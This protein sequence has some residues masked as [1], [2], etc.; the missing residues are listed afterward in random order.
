MCSCL[1]HYLSFKTGR[2]HVFSQVQMNLRMKTEK[3]NIFNFLC[4]GCAI[5]SAKRRTWTKLPFIW[6]KKNALVCV[7][8]V[9]ETY[10]WC[11]VG[12]KMPRTW[13]GASQW[14]IYTN[15]ISHPSGYPGSKRST[16]RKPLSHLPTSCSFPQ[17]AL[18]PGLFVGS[19]LTHLVHR[20]IVFLQFLN[21]SY[22]KAWAVHCN[23][24]PFKLSK[25]VFGFCNDPFTLHLHLHWCLL[26]S[27]LR[28]NIHSSLTSL[29]LVFISL[30]A[31]WCEFTLKITN[32]LAF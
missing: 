28:L 1:A 23:Q 13:W 14:L 16:V 32:W 4:G 2:R 10:L 26:F 7:S 9:E 20:S 25:S 30:I 31:Q 17:A 5:P 15:P 18:M 22:S 29:L 3:K 6:F 19:T 27:R 8:E 11:T 12:V 24:K 21:K